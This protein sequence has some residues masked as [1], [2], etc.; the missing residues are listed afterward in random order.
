MSLDF[1]DP[2][3]DSGQSGRISG[4]LAGSQHGSGQNAGSPAIW[5][6]LA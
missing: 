2:I 3:P 4:Y 1:R 6:D 5:P